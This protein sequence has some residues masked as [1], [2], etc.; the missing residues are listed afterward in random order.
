MLGYLRFVFALLV[1]L[2]HLGGMAGGVKSFLHWGVFAVF[3]FYLMSGFLIT[4]ILHQN[5]SF[6]FRAFALNRFLRIFPVYYLVALVSAAVLLVEPSAGAFH[7]AWR[8][9]LH[10]SDVVGNILV[11]PFE[12]YGAPFRLVPPAWSV[13]V[14]LVNYFL[15]WLVVARSR[16]LALATVL[17][18]IGYHLTS[19]ALGTEWHTH[20]FPWYAALLPFS[21]GTLFYFFKDAVAA[22]P[23]T[24][25][26]WGA[27]V[28]SIAW[29]GNLVACG[30]AS[31]PGEPYFELFFYVNLLALFVLIGCLTSPSLSSALRRSGKF[32]GDLAYPMFLVHWIVGFG[33][34]L[35]FFGGRH[36]GLLLVGL[37]IPPVIVISI[38]LCWL[39]NRWIEPLRNGVRATAGL[40]ARRAITAPSAVHSAR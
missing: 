28:A 2:D 8:V 29:N 37:T 5:Y 23:A 19:L 33:V 22:L 9:R 15:L 31:G 20:Y 1:I 6:E 40:L 12:F 32:A 7:E 13:A 30:I 25:V 27:T 24:A 18:S 4:R 34:S 26:R 35:I 3:G 14:E 11:F 36:K 38:L 16:R 10:A 39:G 21:L 17:L